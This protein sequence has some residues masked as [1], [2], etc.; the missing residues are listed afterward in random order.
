MIVYDNIFMTTKWPLLVL[1]LGFNKEH[2]IHTT[3]HRRKVEYYALN[4][5]VLSELHQYMI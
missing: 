5:N 4:E 2:E 3:V 1:V